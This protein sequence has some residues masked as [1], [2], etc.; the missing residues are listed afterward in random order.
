MPADPLAPD[1]VTVTDGVS[2]N[3]GCP[4][5]LLRALD[6]LASIQ[7]NDRKE[8]KEGLLNPYQHFATIEELLW[9][10]VWKS[11]SDLSRGGTLPGAKGN[12]D[13]RLKSQGFP[14]FL[15]A[16]FRPSDW[17]RL[18][19]KGTFEPM[20]GSFLGKALHKF[21]DPPHE[22]ALYVVG[23]TTYDNLT[24]AVKNQIGQELEK[25]PQIHCVIFRALTHMTHVLSI[26][27]DI[28]DRIFSLLATPKAREYPTNYAVLSHIQQRDKR[29][30]ERQKV[31]KSKKAN[32]PVY[33][34]GVRPDIDEPIPML[35]DQYRMNV[36]SRG[37]DGEPKFEAVPKFLPK[38][39]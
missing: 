10:S 7:P 23:I 8:I 38:S 18:T 32:S 13:W 11:P 30:A 19:D 24:E 27:L 26:Y 31:G 33:C 15:E 35:E 17:P 28:R 6:I 3:L 29:V 4:V 39:S 25:L 36:V 34:W 1:F 9:T 5:R 2:L 14:L 37:S 21:P 12:V 22:A 20:T 16:K